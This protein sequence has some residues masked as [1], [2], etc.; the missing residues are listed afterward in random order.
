MRQGKLA[1]A[2]TFLLDRYG[3]WANHPIINFLLGQVFSLKGDINKSL[4]YLEIG[5]QHGKHISSI[6]V[7][8]AEQLQA[9]NENDQARAVLKL[10]LINSPCDKELLQSFANLCLA[11]QKPL[12]S[13]SINSRILLLFSLSEKTHA[14]IAEA[15]AEPLLINTIIGLPLI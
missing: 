11:D 12:D 10:A 2:E 13:L 9:N 5:Y 8:F 15:Y 4:H 3:K 1:R 6:V 7:L 14:N